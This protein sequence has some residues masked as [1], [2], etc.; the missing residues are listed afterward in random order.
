MAHPVLIVMPNAIPTIREITEALEA[1][2]PPETAQSYDNVG[3]QVGDPLRTTARVLLALDLTPAVL[4]EAIARDATLIITHHPLIFRPLRDV[5]SRGFVNSLALRLAEAGIA[6]YSIHTNLDAAQGGVSFGLAAALGLEDVRF[7]DSAECLSKVTVRVRSADAAQVNEALRAAGAARVR[8]FETMPVRF[9]RLE[10]PSDAA[11]D[12]SDQISGAGNVLETTFEVLVEP[13]HVTHIC[14]AFASVDP[15]YGDECEVVRLEGGA[16]RSGLGAVGV[17]PTPEPLERFLQRV[18]ERL[19]AKTLRYTGQT[20]LPVA[21]VAVCGG[22][23]SDLIP[24]ALAAGADA[25]VTADITYH[26]FF[27]VLDTNGFPRM[28]VIDAGHYETEAMTI[29]LLVE[30]LSDRFPTVSWMKTHSCTSPV[31]RFIVNA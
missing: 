18:G 14:D 5:T 22:S 31:S 10:E 24:R 3:L 11:G 20:D 6:L 7:L 8:A 12:S 27:D 2:A 15:G 28:A 9:S 30:W 19:E 29:G 25:F 23:G 16:A 26:R 1:W 13:W 21:T 17:L 4:D